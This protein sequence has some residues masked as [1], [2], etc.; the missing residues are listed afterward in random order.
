MPPSI[1]DPLFCLRWLRQN[2]AIAISTDIA[3][4]INGVSDIGGVIGKLRS[5]VCEQYP[6]YSITG[7]SV[8]ASFLFF[9]G[10]ANSIILYRIIRSRRNVRSTSS[11]RFSCP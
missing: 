5:E 6:Q 11:A 10:L 3:D 8:S 7:S 9:I 2:V 4:K 1:D